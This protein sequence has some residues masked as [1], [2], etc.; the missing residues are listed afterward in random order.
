VPIVY[1]GRRVTLEVIRERLPNGVDVDLERVI[2]PRV[3]SILPVINDEFVLIR[4]YRP[5]L[6]S[7]VIEI[8]AGTVKEGESDEEAGRRELLE[9]TGLVADELIKI[10]EGY[11]SPGYSTEVAVVYLA[12]NPRWGKARPEP[13]ELIEI[14]KVPINEVPRLMQNGAIKDMRTT[15]AL[16]IYMARKGALA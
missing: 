11:V 9:E 2:F 12:P 3:V 16:L 7:Y 5:V 8:P 10:F 1:G 15:M 14:I 6:R 4:Q 13:H